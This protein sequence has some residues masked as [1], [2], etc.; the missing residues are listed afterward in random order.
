MLKFSQIFAAFRGQFHLM[1]GFDSGAIF[2][3]ALQWPEGIDASK[4]AIIR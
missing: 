2:F 1:K 3:K 4:V